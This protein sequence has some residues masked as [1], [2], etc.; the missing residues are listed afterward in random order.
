[1]TT[2][3]AANLKSARNLAASRIGWTG[4]TE[5]IPYEMSE[6]YVTALARIIVSNPDRFDEQTVA[7]AVKELGDADN[8][9]LETLGAGEAAGIFVGEA[10][11]Q[12]QDI[13]PL[14]EKNRGRTANIL[15]GA[16]LLAAAVFSAVWA[17]RTSPRNPANQ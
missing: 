15:I 17:F 4:R 12:F 7:N 16:I 14:S 8:P 1:M 6:S 3:Q 9:K 10:A 11:N 13:N 5:D 2:Q